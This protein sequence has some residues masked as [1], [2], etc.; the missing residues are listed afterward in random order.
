MG[1]VRAVA[2]FFSK[3]PIRFLGKERMRRPRFFKNLVA[4]KEVL[5]VG[6][7]EHNIRAYD[8]PQWIHRH[9]VEA[10]SYC[11]GIDYLKDGIEFLRSKGFNVL[12]ADAES[13]ELGRQ[14]DVIT[15]G[16]VIEHLSNVG[17]FLTTAH[18]HLK[19]Q[20]LL[21]ITTPNPWFY[22][23]AW[24]ALFGEPE[25]NPEHTAWFTMGTLKEVLR[26]HGFD[27]ESALYASGQDLPWL[28]PILPARMRHTSIWLVARARSEPACGAPR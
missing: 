26:R 1:V 12:Q 16:E 2:R 22:G 20:G 7:I 8:R 3:M 27:V 9:I 28:L 21:V 18:R 11:V 4:G 17:R 15:A 23:R 6:V 5:D 13:F 14:F 25:E 19:P 24:S 10:A